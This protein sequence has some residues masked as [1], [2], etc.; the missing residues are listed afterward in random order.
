MWGSDSNIKC[1]SYLTPVQNSLKITASHIAITRQNMI[2]QS[3][4]WREIWK[5]HVPFHSLAAP[6]SQRSPILPTHNSSLRGFFHTPSNC[7]KPAGC[8][9]FI[10]LTS[11]TIHPESIRFQR[12]SAQSHKT[13]LYFRCQSQSQAVTCASGQLTIN[14]ISTTPFLG[15]D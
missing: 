1:I 4:R 3:L 13:V 6:E 9:T 12:Y 11:D 2:N 10:Q 14:Q 15:F 5:N 8:P 7:Q